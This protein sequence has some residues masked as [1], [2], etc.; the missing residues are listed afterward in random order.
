MFCLLSCKEKTPEKKAL[1][2]TTTN[3]DLYS[4]NIKTDQLNWMVPGS[5]EMDVISY[6][7]FKGKNIIKTYL[8]RRIV[9]VDQ[10]TGKVNWTYKDEVSP[11]QSYYNYDFNDVRLVMFRQYPLIYKNAMIYTNTHGELKSVD[12]TSKKV[13]WTYQVNIPISFSPVLLKNKLVLN[14]GYRVIIVDAGNG[15]LLRGLD[16]KIPVSNDAVVDEDRIYVTDEHGN[17]FCMDEDLNLVW[18]DQ[19]KAPIYLQRNLVVGEDE[20]IF[21]DES[22]FL[23]DKKTG[24]QKWETSLSASPKTSEMSAERLNSL[25]IHDHEISVNTDKSIY[26]LKRNN[27]KILR[28]KQL[29]N[30]SIIGA[31]SYNDGFYYYRCSDKKLY[32]IDKYLEKETLIYTPINYSDLSDD[33]YMVFK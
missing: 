3:G 9:E 11:N 14:L 32:K 27:G 28:K 12:L 13:N 24:K 26:I 15:K 25:E 29:E 19:L 6:F 4:F 2:L 18:N 31:M 23:L 30:K 20:V 10:H 16:F 7:S 8:N 5:P 22:V 21:G 1:I 17:T 33:T